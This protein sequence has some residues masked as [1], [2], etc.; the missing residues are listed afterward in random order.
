MEIDISFF[1]EN[2]YLKLYKRANDILNDYYK[3]GIPKS[4]AIDIKEV[5]KSKRINVIE[6]NM[7]S[8]NELFN[9]ETMGYLDGFAYPDSGIKWSIY[10]NDALGDLTKRYVIAHELAHYDLKNDDNALFTKYCIG[11]MMPKHPE[12]LLCDIEASFLLMPIES[13]FEL[14]DN[15]IKEHKNTKVDSN[16]WL[17]FLGRSL[18]I[19]DYYT[20]IFYQNIRYLA[21]FLYYGKSK[22]DL[23]EE[24]YKIINKMDQY[25]YLFR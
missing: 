24:T 1:M 13:V 14:M 10:V 11:S 17:T 18:G 15:Y 20:L 7:E 19:S 16:R 4:T 2:V 9:N 22:G 21:G 5:A 25:E 6:K 3:E 23:R 8:A 12:E